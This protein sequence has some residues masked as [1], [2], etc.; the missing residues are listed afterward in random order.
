MA[1]EIYG[2]FEFSPKAYT[3]GNDIGKGQVGIPNVN[4][5]FFLEL[6]LIKGHT[7]TGVDSL[8]LSSDATPQMLKGYTP[9]ER[10]ERGTATWT[11]AAAASGS[12]ALTYGTAFLSAPTVYVIAS[13]VSAANIIVAIATPSATGVTIYWRDESGATHTSVDLMY[14]IMG[15]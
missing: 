4:P 5:P 8:V 15:K 1:N 11:G 13:G 10:V 12:V 6:R 3:R 2:N 7:H 9:R 14:L